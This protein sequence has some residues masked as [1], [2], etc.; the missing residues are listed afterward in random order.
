[1]A[2]LFPAFAAIRLVPWPLLYP[3]PECHCPGTGNFIVIQDA[4]LEYDPADTR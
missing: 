1:M 2:S 3:V 4:D